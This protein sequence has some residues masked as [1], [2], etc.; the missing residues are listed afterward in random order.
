MAILRPDL[1]VSLCESVAKKARAVQAIIDELGIN[2]PVHLALAE[3]VL[4]IRS[5]DTLVVRAVAPLAKLLRWFGPHWGTFDQLLV[6]K[7][8]A[9]AG[10]RAAARHLGLLSDLNLRR[11]SVYNTPGTD[12]ESVILR[13]WPGT[14]GGERPTE[15]GR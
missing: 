14:A 5:F 6:V 12:A 7:G 9:W 11:A 15:D 4:G 13:I 2:V 3:E 8:K 10:E 1:R